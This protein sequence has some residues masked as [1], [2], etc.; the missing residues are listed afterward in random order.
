MTKAELQHC[1]RLLALGIE[2][3]VRCDQRR[4]RGPP[5]EGYIDSIGPNTLH[6]LNYEFP[7]YVFMDDGSFACFT[8]GEVEL[9]E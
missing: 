6:E 8:P 5:E 1:R 7:I 2:S 9:L 3:R 4:R